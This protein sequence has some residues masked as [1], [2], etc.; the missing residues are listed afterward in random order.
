M[1]I[2]L[3]GLFGKNIKTEKIAF[4]AKYRE[5]GIPTGYPSANLFVGGAIL[6]PIGGMILYQCS[7]GMPLLKILGNY[8]PEGSIL[9]I[10][11]SVLLGL[12]FITF[13]IDRI[14][15]YFRCR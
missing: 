3:P 8:Y 1:Q 13:G 11:V 2:V 12:G 6:C 9:D 7:Q 14:V 15:Y 5:L 4:E 10:P